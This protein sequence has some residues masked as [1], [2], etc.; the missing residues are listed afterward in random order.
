MVALLNAQ[1][2]VSLAQFHP[3]L[4]NIWYL[5]AAV[6]L[7]VCNQPQEIP[8][9]YHY[10]MQ[11]NGESEKYDLRGLADKTIDILGK[12]NLSLR[13]SID[14]LY[15]RPSALQRQLTERFREAFIKSGPLG[16]LPKAI[17][18]LTQLKD[19]TPTQLLPSTQE[20]DPIK[21]ADGLA[22]CYE[23]VGRAL[24]T[25]EKTTSRGLEHWNHIYSKVSKRVAN[26]LNS[27]YPDLWYYTVAHVYG[28][29]LSYDEI[30][31]VQETNLIIIASL[32][33]QDV[34]PQLRGHLKG[35]LNLGCDEEA[36]EAARNLAIMVSE[37][38]GVTWKA[39]VVKL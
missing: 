21:A 34:N 4:K 35:A 22:P 1:R 9:L 15:S 36:V 39:G 3:K 27:C 12:E 16:G 8:K 32:V 18:V 31:S 5:L 23:S 6:T 30:L 7:S 26:N 29:L 25:P 33:P 14:E 38:C 20:I 13:K 19:V 28:P 17:N 2:L 24:E 11:L 37:W 10:A